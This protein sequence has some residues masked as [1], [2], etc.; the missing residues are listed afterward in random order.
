MIDW[1]LE[2]Y[3]QRIIYLGFYLTKIIYQFQ[4]GS[5]NSPFV[6]LTQTPPHNHSLF[7]VSINLFKTTRYDLIVLFLAFVCCHCSL[8]P[9][10]MQCYKSGI[11]R[12]NQEL[13]M[14]KLCLKHDVISLL[15][16]P[17]F[18]TRKKK[19]NKKNS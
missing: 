14:A 1:V 15:K 8:W 18:G 12:Q 7:S 17:A 11:L 4:N 19:T 5:I 10:S 3:L 9:E 13:Q 16:A 2:E 6:F